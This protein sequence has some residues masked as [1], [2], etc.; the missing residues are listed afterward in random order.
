MDAGYS[1][2]N[3]I[4]ISALNTVNYF[5]N[6]GMSN[7]LVNFINTM[8]ESISFEE[9]KETFESELVNKFLIV[10]HLIMPL[11]QMSILKY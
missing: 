4:I 9:V 11:Q 10:L 2:N 3:I 7:E 8:D 6:Y 5:K 1:K